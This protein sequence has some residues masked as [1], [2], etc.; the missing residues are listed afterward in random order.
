M[1]MP[2][3][4]ALLPLPL[5]F[6]PHGLSS[7]H[8]FTIPV[9]PLP[10]APRATFPE[11]CTEVSSQRWSSVKLLHTGGDRWRQKGKADSEQ[12]HDDLES[13]SVLSNDPSLS[14]SVSQLTSSWPVGKFLEWF[15]K[16]PRPQPPQPAACKRCEVTPEATGAAS[17][18]WLSEAHTELFG[19]HTNDFLLLC[20]YKTSYDSL[21][22]RAWE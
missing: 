17:A 7:H 16:L 22:E 21:R 20:D 8:E 14:A 1:S 4:T 11:I 2:Q 10:C 6:L 9:D 15:S 13:S 3:P 18:L 12:N 5:F 19:K